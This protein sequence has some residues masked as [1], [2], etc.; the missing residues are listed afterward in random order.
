M[1]RASP[2]DDARLRPSHPVSDNPISCLLHRRVLGGRSLHRGPAAGSKVKWSSCHHAWSPQTDTYI[3]SGLIHG[4]LLSAVPVLSVI[5]RKA[6]SIGQAGNQECGTQAK[7]RDQSRLLRC[8]PSPRASA[9]RR[10]AYFGS[11]PRDASPDRKTR[12]HNQ[13]IRTRRQRPLQR[14]EAFRSCSLRHLLK[15]H[16]QTTRS[17]R[18]NS[19]HCPV[20]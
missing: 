12:L 5:R 9:M 7:R 2:A 18:A 13:T 19:K 4:S 14:C 8:P 16:L 6:D 1:Y 3:D 17:A 11:R 15:G 20:M 10:H